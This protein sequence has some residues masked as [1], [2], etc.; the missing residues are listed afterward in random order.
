[1]V[2]N[3][4]MGKKKVKSVSCRP[5]SK[6]NSPSSIEMEGC[7]LLGIRGYGQFGWSGLGP[8]KRPAQY[9]QRADVP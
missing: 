4:K 6:I 5:D 9:V 7:F 8:K 1:M 2:R 3:V